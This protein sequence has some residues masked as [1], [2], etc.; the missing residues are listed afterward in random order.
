MKVV[1][2]LHTKQALNISI[3]IDPKISFNIF[4][5][6]VIDTCFNQGAQAYY[7]EALEF[8]LDNGLNILPNDIRSLENLGFTNNCTFYF[9]N[10]F[11]NQKKIDNSRIYKVL[12]D[13]ENKMIQ[14]FVQQL[15]TTPVSFIFQDILVELIQIYKLD[16]TFS[17]FFFINDIQV[18]PFDIRLMSDFQKN[19]G[20]TIKLVIRKQQPNQDS[21]EKYQFAVNQCKQIK[22]CQK[23]IIMI[24][25]DQ[26]KM[27]FLTS[28]HISL[29]EIF[30][31]II[32]DLQIQDNIIQ[33]QINNKKSFQLLNIQAINNFKFEI[34]KGNFWYVFKLIGDFNKKMQIS[35]LID[36][37]NY[38][39]EETMPIN[40]SIMEFLK[41]VKFK[42][43]GPKQNNYS[44]EL[45]EQKDDHIEL[46]YSMIKK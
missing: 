37:N 5:R 6:G 40:T 36:G 12:V 9:K 28:T 33:Y 2:E 41:D 4:L 17:F 26:M 19:G 30:E 45:I 44:E 3:N 43:F 23:K 31:K 15:Q 46:N 18:Q 21:I 7:E 11:K 20:I 13:L 1:I 24:E 32:W 29:Q 8:Y 16:I 10:K 22:I 34:Y 14:L 35:G 38:V 42:L 25:N 39:I 27:Q